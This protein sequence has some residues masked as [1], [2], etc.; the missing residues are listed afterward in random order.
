[1]TSESAGH[2]A[3]QYEDEAQQHSAVEQGV[4][5]F[6]ASEVMLLGAAIAAFAV[7]RSLHADAFAAASAH[8]HEDLGAINTAILLTSSLTMALAAHAAR[9]QRRRQVMVLLPVTAAMGLG[10]LVVKGFEYASEIREHLLPGVDFALRGADAP[11]QQL[12]FCFYWVLTGLHAVHVS[13]GV[14]M[15]SWLWLLVRRR[16]H[17]CRNA[18]DGGALYWHF[19]DVV[20][21]FLFPLLYLVEA[22][23]R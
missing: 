5:V 8:L 13:I 20:W 22:Y 17:A 23:R 2:V 6:L 10:F 18:V 15:I 1:M 4:W 16:D 3:E 14:A 19:V 21:I 7:Y 11:Q 9:Q 12:F